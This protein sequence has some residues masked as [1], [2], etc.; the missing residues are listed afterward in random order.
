MSVTL[1]AAMDDPKLFA[2][3]FARN[4]QSW[5]AWRAFIAALFGYAMTDDELATYRACCG[6]NGGPPLEAQS[7]AWLVCGRRAGKSFVLALIAVY[8]GCFREYRQFLA[9]GERGVILIIATDRRQ[10][11]TIFRYARALLTEVDMLKRMVEAERSEEIDLSNRI[12]IEIGTASFK[13][14]R[15][16]TLVAMLGDE[17]AFWPAE[18]SASPD[19]E[20]I[21]A[22]RPGMAT[23]PNAVMLMASSPYARKGALWDAYKRYYGKPDAPAL[24]WQ[25]ATRT[26]NPSVRQSV[27]DEAMERDPAAAS[28]EYGAIFRTDVESFVSREAVEACTTPGLYERPRASAHRYFGFVDPS[29]G[30]ADSFTLAIGHAEGK[31]GI[32]D[33]VRERKPPFVP[34]EVVAEFA[35]LLKSYGITKVVGDRYAGEW[36]REAFRG[37][38]ITYEASAAP[39]SDLYKDLLPKLNSGEVDLLDLPRLT[40]QLVGLERRTSRGG[41]DSID[42][43]PGGHDDLANAVAGCLVGLVGARPNTISCTPLRI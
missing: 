16:R 24:V 14:V 27:I 15:G 23:I 22:V 10:A 12:T 33:A 31:V 13:A 5:S 25:A 20:V 2:P 17:V 11:R 8:L 35:A 32:L 40:T 42:H 1:L 41:R 39:K 9:P 26:M 28:A 4:P 3:W 29:G 37:H 21:D 43:G 19:Y 18:D 30:S 34:S 7:E 38:G 36:P 6:H